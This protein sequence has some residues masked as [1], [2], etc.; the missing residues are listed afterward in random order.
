MKDR[1][2]MFPFLIM[3]IDIDILHEKPFHGEHS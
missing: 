2:Y 3:Y 1:G